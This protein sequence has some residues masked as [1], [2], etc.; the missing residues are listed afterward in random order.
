[1]KSYTEEAKK[2]LDTLPDYLPDECATINH[3]DLP[4]IL[5]A[6]TALHEQEM[7]RELIY[8]ARQDDWT[9]KY[10]SYA[11]AVAC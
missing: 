4:E 11:D 5:A 9:Y 2:I 3:N 7:Q 1:M 6:L 8:L 10:A